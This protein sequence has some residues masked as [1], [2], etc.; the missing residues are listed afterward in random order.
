MLQSNALLKLSVNFLR[1]DYNIG[2]LSFNVL[3]AFILNKFNQHK[4]SKKL[5]FYPT[6]WRSTSRNYYKLLNLLI[7]SNRIT[8][9]QLKPLTKRIIV[10]QNGIL[11]DKIALLLPFLLFTYGILIKLNPLI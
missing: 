2:V 8:P 1:Q 9:I 10:N 3:R 7:I 4:T 11:N 6:F 5:N